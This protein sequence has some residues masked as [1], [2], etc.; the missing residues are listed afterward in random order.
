MIE[1]AKFFTENKVFIIFRNNCRKRRRCSISESE[2]E[3]GGIADSNPAQ[4]NEIHGC[5]TSKK[6][7]YYFI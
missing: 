2:D 5:I 1:N 4:L 3:N 7:G 6:Y